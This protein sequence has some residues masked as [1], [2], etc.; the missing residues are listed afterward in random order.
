MSERSLGGHY[1]RLA[2]LF[3]GRGE[4]RRQPEEELDD[5]ERSFRH[6]WRFLTVTSSRRHPPRRKR[7]NLLVLQMGKVASLAIHQAL[8]ET[9]AV[10]AFHFHGVSPGSQEKT[11][12][13]LLTADFTPLLARE[14]RYHVQSVALG[15]LVR[16]YQAHGPYRGHRLKLITLTRDPV[17]HYV[18]NF[19]QRKETLLPEIAAWQRARPRGAQSDE[20]H[21][22]RDF[23]FELVSI[24]AEAGIAGDAPAELARARWPGHPVVAHEVNSCLRPLTWLDAE[25]LAT[26]GLDVLAEPELRRRGWAILQNDWAEVLALRFEQLSSLTPRIAAFAGVPT[27]TLPQR[28]VTNRKAGASAHKAAIQAAI[29]TPAGQ[30][31]VRAVRSSPYARACGYDE[32]AGT[33]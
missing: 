33:A 18:S 28:N 26:V 14:L 6:I 17:N 32:P 13:H 19:I 16:W 22:V 7:P 12:R 5:V 3:L 30:A 2:R 29:E 31:Y 10:N 21:A 11:L 4:D 20:A 27:L 23:M 15:M 25:I 8:S 9:G 24:I 1:R